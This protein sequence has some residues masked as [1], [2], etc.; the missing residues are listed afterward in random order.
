MPGIEHF[1]IFDVFH[2]LLGFGDDPLNRLAFLAA[3]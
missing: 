2:V 3:R 1:G